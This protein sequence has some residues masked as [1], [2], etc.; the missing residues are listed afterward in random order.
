[1]LQSRMVCHQSIKMG[2]QCLSAMSILID[3]VWGCLYFW[4]KYWPHSRWS[5]LLWLH[6]S[7]HEKLVDWKFPCLVFSKCSRGCIEELYFFQ[8]NALFCS[9]QEEW[10]KHLY[11]EK[12]C[13]ASANQS[14][15]GVIIFEFSASDQS[16]QYFY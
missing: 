1:L 14:L 5:G 10:Y 4:R 12:V 2:W 6:R 15:V 16:W 11:L 13:T 8:N 3:Q 9:C 7:G